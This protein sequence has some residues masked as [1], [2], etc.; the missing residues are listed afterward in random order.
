MTT[1]GSYSNVTSDAVDQDDSDVSVLAMSYLMYRIG[2][3]IIL[4]QRCATRITC[5]TRRKPLTELS[6]EPE[7]RQNGFGMIFYNILNTVNDVAFFRDTFQYFFE[8][9]FKYK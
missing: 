8:L 1:T 7:R 9:Y 5:I 2:K 4:F 3:F 6:K